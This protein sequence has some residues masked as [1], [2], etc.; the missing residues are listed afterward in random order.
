MSFT[1]E[2]D[3]LWFSVSQISKCTWRPNYSQETLDGGVLENVPRCSTFV[4]TP[5]IS[6]KLMNSL[7]PRH[8]CSASRSSPCGTFTATDSSL[9]VKVM[10]CIIHTVMRCEWRLIPPRWAILPQLLLPPLSFC[11]HPAGTA[12]A[13]CSSLLFYAAYRKQ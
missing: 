1:V 3:L 5:E 8:T 2:Q 13:G 9:K 11:C 10:K 12:T 7:L 6:A 4:V